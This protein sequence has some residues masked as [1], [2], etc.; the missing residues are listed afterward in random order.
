MTGETG[1][2]VLGRLGLEHDGHFTT[3]PQC[4]DMHY[5]VYGL[6]MCAR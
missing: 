1:S 4:Y 2:A 5:E 3:L 6:A